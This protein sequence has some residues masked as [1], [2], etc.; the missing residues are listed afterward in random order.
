VN[1]I[2]F[3]YD[4]IEGFC[5]LD[6]YEP[7][8]VLRKNVESWDRYFLMNGLYCFKIQAPGR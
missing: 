6:S 8:V 7:Y 1:A 3:Y 5:V 4:N 2:Y